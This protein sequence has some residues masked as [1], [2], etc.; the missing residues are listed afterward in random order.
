MVEHLDDSFEIYFQPFFNGDRP[1]IV[2]VRQNCGIL[3][4]EV[5]DWNLGSYSISNDRWSVNNNGSDIQSPIDQVS[6]YKWNLIN[7]HIE[8]LLPKALMDK[9]HYSLIGTTVFFSKSTNKEALSFLKDGYSSEKKYMYTGI[10]GND[11]IASKEKLITFI[12]RTTLWY[13][14]FTFTKGLYK[15]LLRYLRPPFHQMEEGIDIIYNPEQLQ[16]ISSHE[17]NRQKIKGVAGCG[18]TL[19]LAKRAVNAHVRTSES[20]L[21]LTYNLSLKNYIHDVISDVREGFDWRCFEI[22]NY[23]NFFKAKANNYNLKASSYSCWD[24]VSFFDEVVGKIIKY[25]T[26]IIDEVQDY[27]T[28]WLEIIT[29]YFLA[30]EGEFVV[31]GDEKQ[32]IYDRP[33]ENKTPII[34]TIPGRWNQSLRTTFRFTGPIALLA[35][36]FQKVFL[37]EKY[38][39]DDILVEQTDLFEKQLI[40]YHNISDEYDENEYI[41]KLSKNI[42]TYLMD[43][44]RKGEIHPSDIGIL[45]SKVEILRDLDFLIRNEAHEKTMTTFETLE[46]FDKLYKEVGLD[47]ADLSPK[48][49]EKKEANLEWKIDD[50]R[51]NKKNHFYMKTGTMKLST[52]HSFK[53]WE[54]QTLVLLIE[55]EDLD[56]DFITEELIYTGLTRTRQN[57]LIINTD[58][59]KYDRFFKEKMS[60]YQY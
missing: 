56:D 44:I 38:E 51:R 53:G 14:S 22:N 40:Q 42:F 58:I 9:S 19:V 52:I 31:F 16:L 50:I 18:K 7:L 3:I 29:K 37:R 26:I 36:D 28:E 45:S 27:K 4:I 11:D 17:N 47:K 2:I 13:T 20:V 59:Q 23:H 1:D 57:L 10:M 12:S 43:Q 49:I 25:S 34:R 24:D 8:G 39:I 35:M 32:N 60:A 33:L 54:I 21:I 6:K 46:Y 48:E 15:N 55:D 41:E 30:D 5:K